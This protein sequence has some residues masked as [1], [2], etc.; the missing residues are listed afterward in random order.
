MC[1][2]RVGACV[3]Q[4]HVSRNPAAWWQH[5]G[6][7]AL[8]QCR[9]IS[10]RQA[11]L[12]ELAQRRAQRLRHQVYWP[13]IHTRLWTRALGIKVQ[14]LDSGSCKNLAQLTSCCFRMCMP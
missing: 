12:R 1:C 2:S 8:Q 9:L 10:R 6:H 11:P 7:A 4:E 14:N 13:S 3:A 5:A